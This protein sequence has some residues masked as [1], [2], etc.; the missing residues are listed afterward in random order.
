MHELQKIL[1]AP[2][3]KWSVVCRLESGLNGLRMGFGFAVSSWD[4]SSLSWT[5][6]GTRIGINE[7]DEPSFSGSCNIE[8]RALPT[9]FMVTGRGEMTQIYGSQI[10]EAFGGDPVDGDT[11]ILRQWH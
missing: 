8:F 11:S 7:P 5:R 3:C 6:T 1:G 4:R 9:A 2:V 10:D